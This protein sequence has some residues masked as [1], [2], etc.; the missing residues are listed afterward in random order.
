[1][2]YLRPSKAMLHLCGV[3][4][5]FKRLL[6]IHI[7][8]WLGNLKRKRPLVRPR[9]RWKDSIK[10]D[11]KVIEWEGMDWTH[12]TYDRDHL[13]SLMSMVINLQVSPSVV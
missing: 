1:M 10:M 13:Q 9:H 7:E 11:F 5:I 8:F 3:Y 6:K 4:L 12:L 2:R